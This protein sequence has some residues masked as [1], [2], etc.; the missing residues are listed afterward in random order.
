MTQQYGCTSHVCVRGLRAQMER[1][2]SAA[3]SALATEAHDVDHAD[4]VARL[5][6]MVVRTSAAVSRTGPALVQVSL[7]YRFALTDARSGRQV[8][9]LADTETVTSTGGESWERLFQR[10]EHDVIGRIDEAVS[11]SP[12]VTE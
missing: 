11:R 10:L 2:L 1:G 8:V 12:L 3:L 6:E 9:V 5:Q 7:T 4:Y